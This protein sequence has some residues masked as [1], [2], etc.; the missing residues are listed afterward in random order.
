[1]IIKLNKYIHTAFV[2]ED[3]DTIKPIIQKSI[4]IEDIIIFDFTGIKFYTT[5]FWD[6]FLS[7]ILSSFTIKDF[8]YK[9]KFINLTEYGEKV[10]Y[11]CLDNAK[12]YYS[13]KN[14]DNIKD[15][16]KLI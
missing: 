1:M 8:Y 5:L 3:I 15:Q 12:Q 11:I 9:Y 10:F 16:L 14:I 13:L 6:T 7:I 2:K 4:D